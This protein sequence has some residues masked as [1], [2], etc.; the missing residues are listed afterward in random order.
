[1]IR[2]S[3]DKLLQLVR[4]TEGRSFDLVTLQVLVEE[5]SEAG[6]MRALAA[7]GLEDGSARRDVDELRELLGTWRDVKRSAWQAVARWVVRVLLALL[8]LGLAYRLKL[9]ALLKH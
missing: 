5:A 2:R 6:A 9:T 4:D 8:V 3:S 1:M 7:I